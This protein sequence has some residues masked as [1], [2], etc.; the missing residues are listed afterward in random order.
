MPI[1][2]AIGKNNLIKSYY[3]IMVTSDSQLSYT[4]R[5]LIYFLII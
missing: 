1:N 4:E 3:D 2:I 5:Q